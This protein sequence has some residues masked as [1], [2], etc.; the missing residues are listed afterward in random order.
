MEEKKKEGK[1][2]VIDPQTIRALK[3]SKKLKGTGGNAVLSLR[4]KSD[5]ELKTMEEQMASVQ[6]SASMTK[7]KKRHGRRH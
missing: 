2:I 7:K 4:K 3:I 1:L 5:L 6:S